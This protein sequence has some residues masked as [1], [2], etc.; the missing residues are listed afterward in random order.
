MARA[1]KFSDPPLA[2]LSTTPIGDPGSGWRE[3][4]WRHQHGNQEIPAHHHALSESSR[5][6]SN[7]CPKSRRDDDRGRGPSFFQPCRIARSRAPLAQCAEPKKAPRPASSFSSFLSVFVQ[8]F[9]QAPD[10]LANHVAL[11]R[12]SS[13]PRS[14]STRWRESGA[15]S[16]PRARKANLRPTTVL[17]RAD[18]S[19][20]FIHHPLR[21][22]G[23]TSLLD[24]CFRSGLQALEA[25]GQF[26]RMPLY[27]LA[28]TLSRE[29]AI[30]CAD[31]GILV[32]AFH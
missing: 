10:P 26:L 16:R 7:A 20:I 17:R 13:P 1:H 27:F 28:A 23:D 31:C 15:A 25:L 4:G 8:A 9:W 14:Q 22:F 29:C 19:R 12:R 3:P 30:C 5:C 18:A 11:D 6:P 21:Q 2:P 24:R 32:P